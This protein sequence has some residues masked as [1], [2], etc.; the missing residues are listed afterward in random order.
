[1]PSGADYIYASDLSSDGTTVT[2][3]Y[4]NSSTGQTTSFVWTAAKGFVDLGVIDQNTTQV[5]ARAV[6]GDGT[7]VAGSVYGQN[8][9]NQAF[10]W[11]SSTG[12]IGLGTLG[13]V[14][15]NGVHLIEGV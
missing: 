2:G 7:A 5:I 4:L 1:M 14:P 3:Y 6:S 13:R 8:V 15:I 11:T 9:Y 10:Y 12:I